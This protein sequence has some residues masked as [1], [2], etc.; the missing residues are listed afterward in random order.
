LFEA[1]KETVRFLNTKDTTRIRSLLVDT[2]E[3]ALYNYESGTYTIKFIPSSSI[4]KLTIDSLVPDKKL[5][6]AIIKNEPRVDGFIIVYKDGT[7]H[8]AYSMNFS[9]KNPPR[10]GKIYKQNQVSFTYV[11][12]YGQ[13]KFRLFNITA[14][15]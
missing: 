1:W 6:R 3:Y 4:L 11:P 14:G 15:Q 7:E 13:K 12:V 8:T 2:I 5:Q 10:K 9:R